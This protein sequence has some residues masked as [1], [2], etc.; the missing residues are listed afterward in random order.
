[1]RQYLKFRQLHQQQ[2][3]NINDFEYHYMNSEHDTTIND[4]VITFR[5]R[6]YEYANDSEGKKPQSF[7]IN[8]C[9]QVRNAINNIMN[10]E[11]R[12]T[13]VSYMY[14]LAYDSPWTDKN[15]DEQVAKTYILTPTQTIPQL[16]A[17]DN[18]CY[19]MYN[20]SYGGMFAIDIDIDLKKEKLRPQQKD[21]KDIF[22]FSYLTNR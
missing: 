19:D 3:N 11:Q 6:D 7:V 1:M 10:R 2:D 5:S 20:Q 18:H 13:N 8:K 4:T 17:N 12:T 16:W 22:T 15:G 14:N 21:Y 9:M